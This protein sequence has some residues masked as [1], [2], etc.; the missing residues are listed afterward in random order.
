MPNPPE[1]PSPNVAPFF[2]STSPLSP[3]TNSAGAAVLIV[4]RDGQDDVETLLI[5]RTIRPRDLASGQVALPGGRVDV[6]DPDLRA[7]ALRELGEEV[8]LS[9]ED[10]R[11]PPVYVG[12]E[13][14]QIFSMRVGVFAAELSLGARA[15]RPHSV[16][17]VAHVFWLPKSALARTEV[18]ARETHR[19]PREVE[20]TVFSGHVLWGFTRRVLLEFFGLQPRASPG[21]GR[22]PTSDG[23]PR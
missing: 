23:T 1:S 4:V 5:E 13:D 18:V 19:G 9:P 17:E 12:T 6:G 10:L 15:P 7:T 14:A 2:L 3:P 11:A 21:G 16:S 8:G 22:S 20:A